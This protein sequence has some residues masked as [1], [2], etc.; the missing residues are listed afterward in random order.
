MPE[1]WTP[2]GPRLSELHAFCHKLGQPGELPSS[3]HGAEGLQAPQM[4]RFRLQSN[5]Q[6][7]FRYR[8]L[9]TPQKLP[10]EFTSGALRRRP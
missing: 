9:L 7:G 8:Q 10:I 3:A 6:T 4:R 2:V 1:F 5:L